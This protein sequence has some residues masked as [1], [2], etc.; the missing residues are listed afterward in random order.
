MPVKEDRAKIIVNDIAQFDE[1]EASRILNKILS[2]FSKRHRNI[3]KIF[4]NSFNSLKEILGNINKK[5]P[6][7]L[8]PLLKPLIKAIYKKVRKE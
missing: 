3:S 5:K 2:N 6:L 4:E 8:N 1:E 7:S